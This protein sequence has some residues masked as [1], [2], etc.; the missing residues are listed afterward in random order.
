MSSTDHDPADEGVAVPSGRVTRLMRMGG[1]AASIAGSAVMNGAAELATGSRPRLADL[2]LT[3]ANAR[4]VTAAL[5]QMRGAAMKV[6]QL[7]SMDAGDVLPRE[8][9]DILATL[10]DSAKP[11][12]PAQLGAVLAAEWGRDWRARFASFDV[13]PIAAASIGQVHRARTK[14]GRDL[15]IKVQY[16]G[17]RGSID[18]DVSNVA[19]LI[20]LTGLAPA[21][22]DVTSLL[23]QAKVQLH[24]EADYLREADALADFGALLAG[25][26][27]FVVPAL[28]RDLTTPNLLAMDFIASDPIE[29]LVSALQHVRDEAM[30]ALITLTLRELF[31]FRRMQTDPNFSNYRVQ[32]DSGRIVLLDFGATRT[33]EPG[34]SDRLRALMRAGLDADRDAMR[35]AALA[36]GYFSPASDVPHADGVMALIHTV[37]EP[38]GSTA[39]F[40]FAR[41][42]MVERLR[43]Q[44][45]ALA[46]VPDLWHVP[47]VDTLILHRKFAGLFLLGTR[48]QAVVD[49][50]GLMRPW[51]GDATA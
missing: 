7:L 35:A 15:A 19:G 39:P 34:L 33:I 5:S 44:G 46:Q 49:V 37:L 40:E 27:A 47:P 16:P 6:G 9:A 38:L 24:E 1:L 3:P 2:M 51:R 42:T 36:I 23:E 25:E 45:L 14:D 10:R 20:R 18:S 21:G 29:S 12:P 17:V 31:E 30:A 8:M 50:Q 11:M 26:P 28:H 32:P 22:L 41:T 13:R 43:D 48:L 4:K